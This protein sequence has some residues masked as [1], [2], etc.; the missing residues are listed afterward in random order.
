MQMK[1]PDRMRRKTF[2]IIS[3]ISVVQ[4]FKH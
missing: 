3:R 1:M 2:V 4:Q